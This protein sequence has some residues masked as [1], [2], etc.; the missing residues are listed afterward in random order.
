[1][2]NKCFKS[3]FLIWTTSLLILLTGFNSEGAF[4]ES[5]IKLERIDIIASPITTQGMSQLTL[6]VGNKQ[7]FEAVGHYSDGSSRALSDLT[8]GDWHTSDRNVGHF[9]EP[10]VFIG[11]EVGSTTVTAT[12]DDITSN[13]VNVEVTAAVITAIQ[14]TPATVN[15]AKGQTQQLTADATYSDG[16]SSE[17]SSSVTWMPDDPN[18]AT[19][20]SGGCCPVLKWAVPRL[21]PPRIISPVIRWM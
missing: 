9:D 21:P 10:G 15:V 8:V 19:V 3:L 1:M 18:T 6:A 20:T 2:M 14:V 17:V 7:P 4:S 11:A 16:T 5:A 13:T 12:K